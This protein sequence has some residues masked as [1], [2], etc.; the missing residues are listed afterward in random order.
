M[1]VSVQSVHENISDIYFDDSITRTNK[2]NAIIWSA[3]NEMIDLDEVEMLLRSM[4]DKKGTDY[5]RLLC[6]YDIKKYA[7]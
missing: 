2:I 1:P 3:W 5:R 4:P 7:E 6:V